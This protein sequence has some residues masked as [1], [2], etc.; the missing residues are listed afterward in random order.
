MDIVI[1]D[2]QYL[3]C[4]YGIVETILIDQIYEMGYWNEP[5]YYNK[6]KR[7][8]TKMKSGKMI[9]I[10]AGCS[11][12]F[13][14]T[15]SADA[16]AGRLPVYRFYS[17]SMTDYLYTTD[18]N[19]KKQLMEDYDKNLQTYGYQGIVGYVDNHETNT[20]VPVYRFWNEKTTDHF[21]T[22]DEYEKEV[23]MENTKKGIDQ[24]QYEGIAF[25]TPSEDAADGKKV[26][27]FFDDY[28]FTHYYTDD[29]SEAKTLYKSYNDGTSDSR[30]EGIAWYWYADENYIRQGIV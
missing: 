14:M 21:F 27:R 8:Y 7:G 6:K 10:L 16:V 26:Y 30:Y 12:L 23:V 1:R 13:S 28:T 19:E 18:E 24:Y 4:Y 5:D 25:Y 22:T 15:A 20:N 29:S 9:W 11:L 3:L 2:R 17:A